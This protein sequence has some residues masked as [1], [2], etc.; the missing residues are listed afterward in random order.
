[1]S[2]AQEIVNM[3]IPTVFETVSEHLLAVKVSGLG[4]QVFWGRAIGF[5][6]L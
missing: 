3:K 1:M 4:E 5:I 6:F 2:L